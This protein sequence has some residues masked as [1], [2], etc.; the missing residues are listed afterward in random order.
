MLLRPNHPALLEAGGVHRELRGVG[1]HGGRFPFH[2]ATG[3]A[4]GRFQAGDTD[5]KTSIGSLAETMR[6]TAKSLNV[7]LIDLNAMSI[8]LMKAL[9]AE[10]KAAYLDVSCFTNFGAFEL[11]RCVAKGIKGPDNNLAPFL[12]E[13]I[14]VFDPARP[15]PVNY[16][17]TPG[18]TS[19]IR[20]RP[21]PG[22]RETGALRKVTRAEFLAPGR[23]ETHAADGKRVPIDYSPPD[24]SGVG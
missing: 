16:L 6:Q 4:A 13:E 23:G 8:V 1:A 11:G 15:D 9:G 7:T 2:E 12:V 20:S 14:P 3:E 10:R 18:A 19:L 21:L 24:W 5:S 22:R 17:T